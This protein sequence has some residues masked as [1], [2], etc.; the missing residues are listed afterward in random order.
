M[1]TNKFAFAVVIVVVVIFC[2]TK[3]PLVHCYLNISS[4]PIPAERI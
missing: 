4:P 1:M 3:S 2:G